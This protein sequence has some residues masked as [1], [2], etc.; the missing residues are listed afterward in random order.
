MTVTV[1]LTYDLAKLLGTRRI[2]L[3]DVETVAE[4]VA[5]VRGRFG[6]QAAEFDRLAR[7]TA[8]VVNGVLVSHRKGPATRLRDGDTLGFLKAAAGG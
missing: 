1:E 2:Q 8:V 4:A 7:V 6:A 3:D 5:Q